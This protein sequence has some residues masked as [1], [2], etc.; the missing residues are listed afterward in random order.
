LIARA[1]SKAHQARAGEHSRSRAQSR[2]DTQQYRAN[3]EREALAETSTD[4]A[5]FLVSLEMQA[6]CA[7]FRE[8]DLVRVT[9]LIN[10]TN[11]FNLTTRRYTHA[12]VGA[13][14]TDPNVYTL[15][16]RLKDYFGDNG[17]ISL[18][19]ARDVS[20]IWEIDTWLMSCRVFKRGVEDMV[21]DA[22]VE[23]A[24]ARGIKAIDG[25]YIETPKNGIVAQHYPDRGFEP[26]GEGRWRL[27][28][29]QHVASD[30]PISVTWIE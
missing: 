28:L 29:A 3:A 10:K 30:P 27:D 4:L 18:V 17:I 13:M 11:Q 6:E 15:Q 16:V 1:S 22:L 5:A 25:V 19:I 7:P 8:A 20:G 23:A 2:A 21:L 12:E 9:Q 24:K 26:Q 14:L